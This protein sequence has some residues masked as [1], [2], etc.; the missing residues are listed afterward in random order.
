MDTYEVTNALY[1]QFVQATGRLAPHFND[2]I[3]SRMD[4]PA[5]GSQRTVALTAERSPL[6]QGP[7]SMR[8][9]SNSWRSIAMLLSI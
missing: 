4:N 3:H 9:R 5:G 8:L 7:R 2:P 1:A 6:D